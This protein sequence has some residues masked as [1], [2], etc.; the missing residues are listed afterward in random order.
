[1]SVIFGVLGVIVFIALV[2]F[3]KWTIE[4]KKIKIEADRIWKEKKVEI[5]SSIES[6]G[7]EKSISALLYT[8]DKA[9]NFNNILTVPNSINSPW[10]GLSIEIKIT[11]KVETKI[12]KN[13]IENQVA[14]KSFLAINI[15]RIQLRNGKRQNVWASSR[16]LQKSESLNELFKS[17]SKDKQAEALDYL[18]NDQIRVS[19]GLEWLQS[20]EYPY[21]SQCKKRMN[22]IFQ[23]P[24]TLFPKSA[25]FDIHES[26][27]Y[28]WLSG[29]PRQIRNSCTV[30]I[31]KL[32]RDYGVNR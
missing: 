7:Q 1:M 4:W 27:I 17:I 12:V 24:G 30:W 21:C 31:K 15:P 32:T 25:S 29:A 9:K 2:F 14:G 20:A 3:V 26:E 23:M 18:L 8:T 5:I 10:S 28:I 16:F 22:I 6:I 19:G 11:N 13:R